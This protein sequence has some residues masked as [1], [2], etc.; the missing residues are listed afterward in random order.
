M[1]GREERKVKD[2]KRAIPSGSFL[3]DNLHYT[4]TP[5]GGGRG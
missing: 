2:G 4:A 3:A 1:G 5:G